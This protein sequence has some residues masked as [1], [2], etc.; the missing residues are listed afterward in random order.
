MAAGSFLS[1]A[2]SF[3]GGLG[4]GGGEKRPRYRDALRAEMY[5]MDNRVKQAKI[6]SEKY[7]IHP[8]TILGMPSTGSPTAYIPG[9]KGPDLNAMG[10]V[11]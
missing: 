3:L 5:S 9:S 11:S 10:L 8:L 4:L 7:G 1:G 2:G 6:S